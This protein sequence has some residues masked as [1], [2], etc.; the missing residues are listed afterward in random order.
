MRKFFQLS[1]L[2][3]SCLYAMQEKQDFNPDIE[4]QMSE[5]RRKI[6][7][8]EAYFK[9]HRS[10]AG[11]VLF[12]GQTGSGKSTLLNYLIGKECSSEGPG[13]T[14]LSSI[15]VK[16]AFFPIGKS[17]YSV[18]DEPK[19]WGSF[20]DMPGFGD[21]QANASHIQRLVNAY[22]YDGLINKA[23]STKIVFVVS[24]GALYNGRDGYFFDNLNMLH[25]MFSN[26]RMLESLCMVVTKSDL[27]AENII[28]MIA[29]YEESEERGSI[30]KIL[31]TLKKP[32]R[33][34]VFRKPSRKQEDV[35]Q[36]DRDSIEHVI[37]NVSANKF[38][39]QL[40]NIINS[41]D[42][43]KNLLN[44]F[45]R[46]ARDSGDRLHTHMQQRLRQWILT[47]AQEHRGLARDLRA[48]YAR[49]AKVFAEQDENQWIE[50][51]QNSFSDFQE[52]TGHVLDT[53]VFQD[54]ELIHNID[55]VTLE[56]IDSQRWRSNIRNYRE[57][58]NE[59]A[60]Q[61]QRFVED[62]M[63]VIDGY[64]VGCDDVTR[65]NV[66]RP[67]LEVRA[68]M[69]F[70][71]D[72][73]VTLNGKNVSIISPFVTI[74]KDAE[75]N[76]QGLPGLGYLHPADSGQQSPDVHVRSGR[77]G[78]PG[79]PGMNGGNFHMAYH[80]GHG[81]N[82][83][84][85]NLSGGSG[86]GGQ[87]GG[88]GAQGLNYTQDETNRAEKLVR[89]R[90]EEALIHREDKEGGLM[91]Y[92]KS[93]LT[94]TTAFRETYRATALGKRGGDAGPGGRGGFGGLSGKVLGHAQGLG[95][96]MRNNGEE[97][98]N[99]Q[100]GQPG[101]GGQNHVWRG[102]YVVDY[103]FP[104]L[105]GKKEIDGNTMADS[106]GKAQTGL[107][108]YGFGERTIG[109]IKGLGYGIVAQGVISGLCM[110][111]DRWI[112]GPE[113]TVENGTLSGMESNAHNEEG[114]QEPNANVWDVAPI[115][116]RYK[117]ILYKSAQ[118]DDLMRYIR[119]HF[120]VKFV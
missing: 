24:K 7:K 74:T 108:A 115:Q 46:A 13:K 120:E 101:Q 67:S 63:D 27:P 47:R 19:A 88:R 110:L 98:Q 85:L 32:G 117:D 53:S 69:A 14:G 56:D 102:I 60:S 78:Q 29:E 89:D 82:R 12:M 3:V 58:L 21:R 113:G 68:F 36:N 45:L 96:I 4:Q 107:L 103:A 20:W 5:T 79:H 104:S 114:R 2:T 72:G 92:S 118:K 97:G 106:V 64:I 81:L 84:H 75:F 76:L 77:A 91:K 33:I 42:A 31:N 10:D 100:H 51:C 49:I 119:D 41:D 30:K 86:H 87:N 111:S 112:E 83:L 40:S 50:D 43:T 55:P 48:E 93:F 6:A 9:K 105:R 57:L 39:V 109:T 17:N 90:Q 116:Q 34:A 52:G 1:L 16:D 65:E 37:N 95:N 70:Y 73:N 18:T 8:V 44:G 66:I 28:H 71:G 54:L 94:Y 99:G 59:V 25:S 38:G 80:H 15:E 23:Q 26:S 22:Y 35:G 62:E 61:P 11:T